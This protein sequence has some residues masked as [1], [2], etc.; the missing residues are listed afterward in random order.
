ML[1]Q[2]LE[3]GYGG[4]GAISRA[5]GIAENTI[6]RGIGELE[7]IGTKSSTGCSVMSRATGPQT[8]GHN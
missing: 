7:G 4:I 1:I 8:R 5:A 6:K 2:A 3:L